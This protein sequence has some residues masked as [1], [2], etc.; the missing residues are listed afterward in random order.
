MDDLRKILTRVL[1][2]QEREHLKAANYTAKLLVKLVK[3][4]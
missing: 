2:E 3:E 4:D 1:V